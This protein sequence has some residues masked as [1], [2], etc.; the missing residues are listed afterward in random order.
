MRRSG[1]LIVNFLYCPAD[2]LIARDILADTKKILRRVVSV[3]V[4][5]NEIHRYVVPHAVLD[6]CID[7]G[8]LRGCWPT[9][10]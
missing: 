3:N 6:E 9:Y 7:P 10:A 1:N 4:S 5:G 8:G 2:E